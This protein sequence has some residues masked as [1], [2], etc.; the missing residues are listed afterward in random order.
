MTADGVGGVWQYAMDL[1]SALG[2][3]GVDVTL[4]VMGPPLDESQHAE[5]SRQGISVLEN[6]CK[7]E[8]MEDPWDDLARAGGWLRELEETFRPDVVH[9][10]GY[11][12]A[13]L[14]WRAPAIVVGHSCVRSWWRAVRGEGASPAWDR[15]SAA[16]AAGLGAARMVVAPT[17]AMRAAL[18]EEYGPLSNVCVIPNG[19][20]LASRSEDVVSQKAELILAAGRIWD[21]AKNIA[22]LCEVAPGLPWPVYVAGDAG[23]SGEAD[24]LMRNVFYLGRLSTAMLADWYDRAAI[25]ALP[26]RYEPFGLSVLEAAASGCALVLGDI[27]SLRENWS[28][29]ALFVPPGDRGA[30]Q[31]SI[32]SLI[33]DP[34]RRDRLARRASA[35]AAGL[36]AAHMAD[37]YLDA[38]E[39]VL[40]RAAVA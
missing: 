20:A 37:R 39:T 23:P 30:L 17:E 6:S 26:A 10:N 32:E 15:Y 36:T 33:G 9:L 8:W 28:D 38:Y 14:A 21:D 31:A 25:Y 18:Q 34:E 35:R 7:L 3:R 24:R 22:A 12:H 1:S 19:R 4:A 11:C 29:A 40:V 5:A 16:V 2:R 27:R 13:T